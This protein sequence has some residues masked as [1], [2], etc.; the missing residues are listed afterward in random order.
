MLHGPVR[1]VTWG[2]GGKF[3]VEYT[4][5]RF[6][7]RV[8][9]VVSIFSVLPVQT[10]DDYHLDVGNIEAQIWIRGLRK[11]R[12]DTCKFLVISVFLF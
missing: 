11:T 2:V 4:D 6:R 9:P 10:P 3:L 7:G 1:P 8:P 12:H 5:R